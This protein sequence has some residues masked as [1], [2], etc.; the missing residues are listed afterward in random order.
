MFAGDQGLRPAAG[1]RVIKG[2]LN[3]DW[4]LV[5]EAYFVSEEMGEGWG[6][7]GMRCW[8]NVGLMLAQRRRR[9]ANIKPASAQRLVFAG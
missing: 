3:H 2:W 7:K 5:L 8:A 4:S 9:W 6:D 1:G